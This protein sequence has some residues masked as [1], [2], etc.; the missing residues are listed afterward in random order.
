MKIVLYRRPG[1]H[2][3]AFEDLFRAGLAR[4]GV[5]VE[6][7]EIDKPVDCDLAV[8]WGVSIWGGIIERQRAAGRHYLVME[9]GYLGDRFRWTSL[10]LNG[11]NGRA[12]FGVPR[13]VGSERLDRHF[14][15]LLQPAK[16]ISPND[17]VVIMGQ[18]P[19]DASLKHLSWDDWLARAV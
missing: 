8:F 18:V 11:L 1:G 15:G 7:A 5:Y 16:W 9:R 12:D 6:L 14:P 19:G 4:H 10:G 13:D 3:R 17:P 2:P